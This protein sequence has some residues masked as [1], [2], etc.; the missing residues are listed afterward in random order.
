MQRIV[1][2]PALKSSSHVAK[3]TTRF[4][5]TSHARASSFSSTINSP[6]GRCT[7]PELTSTSSSK[8]V[9]ENTGRP[10]STKST[11]ASQALPEAYPGKPGGL[12]D[13]GQL[14]SEN[15]VKKMETIPNP[16]PHYVSDWVHNMV[17][18]SK[19]LQGL[20]YG[21]QN[22][23]DRPGLL[24]KLKGNSGKRK[25]K[26]KDKWGYGGESDGDGKAVAGK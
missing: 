25:G 23:D 24:G 6:A 20:L 11:A 5:S 9:T 16:R 12:F 14:E 8:P 21:I 19:M 26:Q 18:Q 4:A 10:V 13:N 22:P 17:G 2:R 3:I 15:P 7:K 1:A